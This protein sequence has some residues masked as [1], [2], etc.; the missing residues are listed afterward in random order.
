MKI[1]YGR[2]NFFNLGIANALRDMLYRERKNF[3]ESSDNELID[4][5]KKKGDAEALAILYNRYIHLVYGVCLKYLRNKQ[6]SEDAAM[7]IFEKLIV[8]VPKF[9]IKN[10]K[11]WLHVLSRNF[12]LMKLRTFKSSVDFDEAL[13]SSANVEF[14]SKL[15]H[16]DEESIENNLSALEK[17]LKTLNEE[18]RKCIELFYLKEKSYR[19]IVNMEGYDLK[20]VKS[21]I[22]NGKRN[23]KHCIEKEIGK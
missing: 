11:S 16:E 6:D 3:E 5:F 8:E 4:I 22:Q 23:I 10:F 7:Q 21:H 18:Q 15:H 19:E 13:I 20:N 9:E 2:W 14:Q 17:C 12:C 1:P